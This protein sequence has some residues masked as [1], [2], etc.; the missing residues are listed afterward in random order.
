MEYSTT[1]EQD[2][3]NFKNQIDLRN[4]GLKQI[5]YF[6][7]KYREIMHL[8]IG[9]PTQT[10]L[11]RVQSATKRYMEKR[12]CCGFDFYTFAYN[13][14]VE[15]INY[16]EK[17]SQKEVYKDAIRILD[18]IKLQKDTLLPEDKRYLLSNIQNTTYSHT[19]FQNQAI[20][21]N[22]FSVGD[23]SFKHITH[24]KLN[25]GDKYN[26]IH[27]IEALLR[28][29]VW[30]VI[31]ALGTKASMVIGYEKFFIATSKNIQRGYWSISEEYF[32]IKLDNGYN[33]QFS[34]LF[35]DTNVVVFKAE[36]DRYLFLLNKNALKIIN[37]TSP[38]DIKQYVE[39]LNGV[40]SPVTIQ[41]KQ[42]DIKTHQ[43]NEKIA[44]KPVKTLSAYEVKMRKNRKKYSGL[45][46]LGIDVDDGLGWAIAQVIFYIICGIIV[47]GLIGGLL[48]LFSLGSL[49][50]PFAIWGVMHFGK[51]LLNGGK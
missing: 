46:R 6:H 10:A 22:L 50:I 15:R 29:N 19:D 45:R 7:K 2:Y 16:L 4:D 9:D 40:S 37:P 41:Q 39:N 11:K 42:Q 31:S 33:Y 8:Y 17:S 23:N 12:V 51:E 36:D 24:I 34:I 1:S 25:I 43:Q 21:K 18:A 3:A 32:T 13:H 5:E 27:D 30:K 44:S 38:L 14:F 48:Y 35:C 49:A 47:I 20:Q 26:N 28:N